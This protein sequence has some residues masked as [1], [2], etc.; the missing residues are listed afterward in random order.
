M[1][2]IDKFR[3]CLIGGAAGDALGYEVEFLRNREIF[4]RFG[5]RG[6]TEYVLHGGLA[7]ISD[8]T[9]MTMFTATGLLSCKTRGMRSGSLG[10]YEDEIRRSY[11]D[12]Y[13]TQMEHYPL[14]DGERRSWLTNVP[15][16]FSRRAPGNTCLSALASEEAATIAHPIN[17]KKGCGGV[18]RVAP[19]GL[20]FANTEM[21]IADSDRIGGEAAAVTHGHPLGWLPG[22]ALA[23]IIRHLAEHDGEPILTAVED[24]IAALAEVFPEEKHVPEFQAT[25]QKAVELAASDVSDAVAIRKLGEGW[26]GDEAL[27]ISVYCVLKHPDSCDDAIIASVNHRGDSD[28]TGAITGNII[29]SALGLSAIPRKY[30][31]HLELKAE[32]LELADDLYADCRMDADGA[33]ADPTWEAKYVRMDYS[34]TPR[35]QRH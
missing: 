10:K 25:L 32:L 24:A 23:H 9:Q 4:E 1:R 21:P 28:S 2:S 7:R 11:R 17:N 34:R 5:D 8:D 16:L 13:R 26:V 29:G 14:P 15:A 22:A 31:D 6:I 20:Y 19:V 18:M 35:V 27:A 30:L 33:F 3:G 12:W